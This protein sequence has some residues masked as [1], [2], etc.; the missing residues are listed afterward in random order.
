M[1]PTQELLDTMKAQLENAEDDVRKWKDKQVEADQ[2]LMAALR[3]RN[4]RKKKLDAFVSALGV[5][6]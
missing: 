3:V 2:R 5:S 1:T 4:E 6:A